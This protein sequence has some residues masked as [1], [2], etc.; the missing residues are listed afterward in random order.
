[1]IY[2]SPGRVPLAAR[3]LVAGSRRPEVTRADWLADGGG[4]AG[5]A[6]GRQCC[7]SGPPEPWWS[8][9]RRRRVTSDPGESP[10]GRP[11]ADGRTARGR[12]SG[13]G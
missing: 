10:P 11:V 2:L 5:A 13:I 4:G 12:L 7:S 8:A 3:R 9:E 6:A 1:M